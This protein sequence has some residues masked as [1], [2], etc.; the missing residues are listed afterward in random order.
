MEKDLIVLDRNTNAEIADLFTTEASISRTIN[1]EFY[2]S[3]SA[4][5]Q[6][7]KTEYLKDNSILA[8]NQ[9]FDIVLY[10]KSHSTGGYVNHKC[11]GY[12]VFYRLYNENTKRLS[13]AR[14]ATPTQ[15]LTEI[16]AGTGFSVGQ[17]DYNNII[18][19]AVNEE[20]TTGQIVMALANVLGGEL[21]YSNKGFTINILDS[22]GT[23]NGFEIS[24]G[25]NIK[26]ITEVYDS[27]GGVSFSSYQVDILELKNSV[28]YIEKGLSQLE[29]IE[30]GD[31]VYLIDEELGINAEQRILSKTYDPR[32]AK[33]T[34]VEI[35]NTIELFTDSAVKVE[36]NAVFKGKLYY[37][38]K[39]SPDIGF[40]CE[41]SDKLA[42]TIMNADEFR[43]QK[44]DGNGS[45]TDSLYFDPIEQVYKFTGTL[46]ANDII[47][48]TISGSVI[49]G[50]D[51]NGN[52]ITGGTIS[53]SYMEG[54]TIQGGTIT[55]GSIIGNSIQGNT[56][57]GGSISIGSNFSVDGNGNMVA[58]NAEFSGDITG[59]SFTGGSISIGSNFSVDSS[60]NM[61]ASNAEFSGDIT[62]SSFIGG[63][64]SIGSNF[65]V[66]SSGNMFANNAE[67]IGDITGSNITGSSITGGTIDVDTDVTIGS[68][69]YINATNFTDGIYFNTSSI[70]TQPTGNL[71]L[72]APFVYINGR[73]V[74][75]IDDLP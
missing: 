31:T 71:D 69:L 72:N 18:T 30:L 39:I 21:E 8:D 40:E 74:L 57:T 17:V 44:G 6:E 28:E 53:G 2:I 63:S 46:E 43:M 10:E 62:G 68:R 5:E 22:I 4:P 26:A 25:K 51:I 32:F 34:S 41:R 55:G 35:A 48:G 70:T 1:Q 45:Y 58:S 12:H 33:N 37:G 38:I 56:I 52:N 61:V 9:T 7:M 54:G 16:L 11:E 47:G 67:F 64:I 65:S 60:G 23:N 15:I 49:T 27:R 59:S 13:Y 73:R 14:Y 19:F 66:D 29:V 75:T 42:R 20:A 24:L 36:S 3:F 50:S